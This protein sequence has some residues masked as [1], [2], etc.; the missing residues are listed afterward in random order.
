MHENGIDPCF[1]AHFLPF[2]PLLSCCNQNSRAAEAFWLEI[3]S[4]MVYVP[5]PRYRKVD[6]IFCKSYTLTRSPKISIS[7][8][9]KWLTSLCRNHRRAF[10][11]PREGLVNTSAQIRLT[12]A[13]KV[14]AATTTW[15]IDSTRSFRRHDSVLGEPLW[16]QELSEVSGYLSIEKCSTVLSY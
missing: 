4:Q 7:Y 11:H 16:T 9:V 12:L 8:P 3:I 5:M 6:W 10:F 14:F 1:V 2:L 15:S 13:N